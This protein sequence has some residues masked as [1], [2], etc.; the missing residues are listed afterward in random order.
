MSNEMQD[1]QKRAAL[2]A[3]SRTALADVLRSVQTEVDAVKNH[4]LPRIRRQARTVAD[5]HVRLTEQIRAHSDL[6][7]RPR[8]QTVDGLRFGLMK[9]RG[10][11]RWSS[12]AQL[13]K[14]IDK[15]VQDGEI[16]D[17]QREL[18][19]RT[20]EKP[21][22]A[23]LEKLDARLLKRLG[24]TVDADC[25]EVIIKSVDST[26]EKMVNAVIKGVTQDE[27]AEVLA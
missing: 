15:L 17:E 8:T 5:Q 9:R 1:L 21:S 24:V 10:K 14:R 23:A 13:V 6:F 20:T 26:V 2:L 12:D 18:L 7:V 19:V 22:A 27:N 11:M 25:D 3:T 4:S 16:T